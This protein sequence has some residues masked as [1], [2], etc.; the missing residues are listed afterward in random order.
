MNNYRNRKYLS[1]VRNCSFSVIMSAVII[2][3]EVVAVTNFFS[4]KCLEFEKCT[5]SSQVLH[6]FLL[7]YLY[8]VI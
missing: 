2:N 8:V 3:L 1:A 5:T 7:G 6:V 4:L